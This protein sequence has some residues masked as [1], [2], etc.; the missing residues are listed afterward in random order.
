MEL[1]QQPTKLDR[2]DVAQ[3][4]FS[5]TKLGPEL[6]PRDFSISLSA[7]GSTDHWLLHPGTQRTQPMRGFEDHYVDII[8]YRRPSWTRRSGSVG[9]W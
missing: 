6:M 3:S 7:K 4:R 8:D 1:L 2:T 9:G 5:R